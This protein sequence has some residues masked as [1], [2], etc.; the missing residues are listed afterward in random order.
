M[1]NHL[2]SNE[3]ILYGI[4]FSLLMITIFLFL[5][6]FLLLSKHTGLFLSKHTGPGKTESRNRYNP[7]MYSFLR[8][9]LLDGMAR[10]QLKTLGFL[11]IALTLIWR[12][13]SQ[14]IAQWIQDAILLMGNST[15]GSYSIPILVTGITAHFLHISQLKKGFCKRER[16]LEEKVKEYQIHIELLIII[17]RSQD[18]DSSLGSACGG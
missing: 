4:I 3:I 16:E 5:S 8:D 1:L 14:Q 11:L 12:S 13:G 7:N 9:I 10:G 6:N 15:N 18:D 17:L 2:R